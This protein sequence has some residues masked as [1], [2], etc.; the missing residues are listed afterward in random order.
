[1]NPLLYV[2]VFSVITCLWGKSSVRNNDNSLV[3][4]HIH[5]LIEVNSAFMRKSFG[6]IHEKYDDDDNKDPNEYNEY[7]YYQSNT[8]D[9]RDYYDNDLYG[10]DGDESDNSERKARKNRNLAAKKPGGSVASGST[11]RAS[12][13]LKDRMKNAAR[14][15]AIANR[16]RRSG[17][18]AAD[19]SRKKGVATSRANGP[20]ARVGK[21]SRPPNSRAKKRAAHATTSSKTFGSGSTKKAS[22]KA[23]ASGGRGG[24]KTK[25]KPGSR[26]PKGPTS[27]SKTNRKRGGGTGLNGGLVRGKKGPTRSPS[28]PKRKWKSTRKGSAKK[29]APSA[30]QKK[31]AKDQ[32]GAGSS[33]DDAVEDPMEPRP[34]PKAPSSPSKKKPTRRISAGNNTAGNN[35]SPSRLP[36]ALV[37]RPN[38]K[39]VRV[40]RAPSGLFIPVS[41]K[42]TRVIQV[43]APSGNVTKLVQAPS[44]IFY[45][46]TARPSTARP[47]RPTPR[48]TYRPTTRTPTARA[49]NHPALTSDPTRTPTPRPSTIAEGVQKDS[50]GKH[51]QL[52]LGTMSN[53]FPLSLPKAGSLVP[54]PSATRSQILPT[55]PFYQPP[56]GTKQNFDVLAD[57]FD[58]SPDQVLFLHTYI[59][60]V[61][62]CTG[63]MRINTATQQVV[64]RVLDGHRNL[65]A[66]LYQ[67]RVDNGQWLDAIISQFSLDAL[68]FNQAFNRAIRSVLITGLLRTK[69]PAF[70]N[71]QGLKFAGAESGLSGGVVFNDE[72]VNCGTNAPPGTPWWLLSTRPCR[73]LKDD[74]MELEE[75]AKEVTVKLHIRPVP[76]TELADSNSDRHLAA[77]RAANPTTNIKFQPRR[78][79]RPQPTRPKGPSSPVKSGTGVRK[80]SMPKTASGS[81]SRVTSG[82]RNVPSRRS[83]QSPSVSIS[84]SSS[85]AST[86]LQP[87]LSV[88]QEFKQFLAWERQKKARAQA[89]ATPR[90][91]GMNATRSHAPAQPRKK[92]PTASP[93]STP[94]LITQ[95]PPSVVQLAG[96]EIYL[97]AQYSPDIIGA[98]S[99]GRVQA[100]E[101]ICRLMS[102]ALT[103]RAV[104]EASLRAAASES[105]D[106]VVRQTLSMAELVGLVV[107]EPT[108]YS[109][110]I[111]GLRA[112]YAPSPRPTWTAPFTTG[113]TFSPSISS[114]DQLA[115]PPS[116]RPSS[117]P[118]PLPGHPTTRP[119]PVPT[120]PTPSPTRLPT[121]VPSARPTTHV[122]TIAPTRRVFAAW[123]PPNPPT[124]VPSFT[125]MS[126][127]PSLDAEVNAN[128]QAKKG[129]MS[130]STMASLIVVAVLIP[131]ISV[132]IYFFCFSSRAKAAKAAREEQKKAK[133]YMLKVIAEE[134]ATITASTG[135]AKDD[136]EEMRTSLHQ[137][138]SKKSPPGTADR[139]ASSFAGRY[140]STA[141]SQSGASAPAVRKQSTCLTRSELTAAQTTMSMFTPIVSSSLSPVSMASRRASAG[142]NHPIP[143]PPTRPLPSYRFST[144]PVSALSR[145]PSTLTAPQYNG[146]DD[147]HKWE[148]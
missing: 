58:L 72:R 132:V 37:R 40:Y 1:M 130:S 13:A 71:M 33:D 19:H 53:P 121:R 25:R 85:S 20:K 86:T 80:G 56:P 45:P 61:Y 116:P 84:P 67:Q 143:Q 47:T 59:C 3:R 64:M 77:K 96:L 99:N 139:V 2:L 92:A 17:T 134:E 82:G 7:Y 115:F 127:A 126:S 81:G 46:A 103:N 109:S 118:T 39:V 113:P 14:Q 123:I 141:Y 100:R 62:T 129:D 16:A 95:A 15:R 65:S 114:W 29:L 21:V 26:P 97:T 73:K 75:A 146:G 8:E 148:L 79:S 120:R 147:E 117:H 68:S 49:T 34:S 36:T 101:R 136:L 4:K 70:E 11:S 42:P 32:S 10:E 91:R 27:L 107:A 89:K 108:M 30:S 131:I 119:S 66:S 55:W 98:A 52:G 74:A 23:N 38:G 102:A 87:T 83:R 106:P 111:T 9:G 128:S 28:T 50:H 138:Y 124:P 90:S 35:T 140:G 104:V 133:E 105:V 48:P 31:P 54:P 142:F 78:P 51:G 94:T 69:D 12:T 112:A 18:T 43:R 135:V 60:Q 44:G 76:I 93:T 145:G 63:T 41:K 5:E 125:L 24:V 6:D 110:I 137:F 88:A 57:K 144:K 122:P 22:P